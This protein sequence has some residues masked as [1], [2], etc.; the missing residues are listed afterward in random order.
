[1]S[2]DHRMI[3]GALASRVL[4]HVANFVEDPAPAL[5]VG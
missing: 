1:M 3:D 2:F 5:I 4:R